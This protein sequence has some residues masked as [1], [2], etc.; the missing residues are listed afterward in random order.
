[1][2]HQTRH[3]GCTITK[4]IKEVENL[5]LGN[6]K[7]TLN[8]WWETDSTYKILLTLLQI[9][10][11]GIRESNENKISEMKLFLFTKVDPWTNSVKMFGSQNFPPSE[12]EAEVEKF[13][14]SISDLFKQPKELNFNEKEKFHLRGF[15]PHGTP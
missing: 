9:T 4:E 2:C 14:T 3:A 15:C 10:W 12:K 5:S 11:K 7:D 13:Q 1:M 8:I 6:E